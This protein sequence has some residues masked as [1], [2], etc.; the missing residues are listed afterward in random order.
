LERKKYSGFKA[1]QLV[2]DGELYMMAFDKK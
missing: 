1:F 2:F